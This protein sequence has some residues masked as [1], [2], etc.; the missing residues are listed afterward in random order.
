MTISLKLQKWRRHQPNLVPGTSGTIIIVIFA[1]S[2]P[3]TTEWQDLVYFTIFLVKTSE[4]DVDTS[5]SGPQ[6]SR[7]P[8]PLRQSCSATLYNDSAHFKTIFSSPHDLAH[9]TTIFLK[10]QKAPWT[11]V[12]LNHIYLGDDY[13]S[14]IHDQ[15]PKQTPI[16]FIS[17]QF[18]WKLR[19]SRWIPVALGIRYLGE[20]YHCGK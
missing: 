7:W 18:S 1:F 10:P 19:K 16:W 11:P 3:K 6:V 8:L 9:F 2:D 17:W 12:A 15:P 5:R 13:R 14:D 4:D 20:R